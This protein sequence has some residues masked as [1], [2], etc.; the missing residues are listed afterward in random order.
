MECVEGET[1]AGRLAEGPLTVEQTPPTRSRSPMRSTPRIAADRPSESQAGQRH[2]DV[3]RSEAARFRPGKLRPQPAAVTAA[4]AVTVAAPLTA[5]GTILETLQ[6][7]AP[8]QVEGLD[9]D[10]RADIWAFGCIVHE[11][12]TGATAFT[13]RSPAS[14]ARCFGRASITA[15]DGAATITA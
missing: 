10:H 11:M 6:Y 15:S 7:M 5:Q 12:L 4:T 8:A 1:L 9:A 3:R 2:A 14:Q 13:G